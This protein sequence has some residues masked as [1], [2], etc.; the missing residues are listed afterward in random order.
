MS[1]DASWQIEFSWSTKSSSDNAPPPSLPHAASNSATTVKGP[2]AHPIRFMSVSLGA[3][4]LTTANGVIAQHMKQ[5]VPPCN[6]S[7]FVIQWFVAVVH[8]P[9]P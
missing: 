3:P 2:V 7:S 8:R 4:R 6:V 9:G 1:R 5:A